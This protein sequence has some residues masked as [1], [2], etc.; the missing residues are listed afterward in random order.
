[1]VVSIVNTLVYAYAVFSLFGSYSEVKFL[2]LLFS[3]VFFVVAD[4]NV[5]V[6]RM[7]VATV[8]HVFSILTALNVVF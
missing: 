6:G 4:L 2:Y 5:R 3:L 1:V 8:M 7:F